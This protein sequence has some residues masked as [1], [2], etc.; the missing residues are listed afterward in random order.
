MEREAKKPGDIL[1][2]QHEIFSRLAVVASEVINDYPNGDP[3]LLGIWEG[4]E[5]VTKDF[6]K[7][8][9]ARGRQIEYRA[10]TFKSYSGT[11]SSG[12]IDMVNGLDFN[13]QGQDLLLVDDIIDTGRTL[14]FADKFLRE[15]GA[16]SVRSFALLSKPT[17]REVAYEPDYVGFVIPDIWVEGYGMDSD[18]YGR[19]NPH[20]IVGPYASLN[21]ER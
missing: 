12:T 7:A 8:L 15:K 17:R 5:P 14:Q 18:G 9:Q 6:Q 4:A 13:P 10:I 11:T 19:E 16:A 2:H 1:K 3:T 20:I 21:N